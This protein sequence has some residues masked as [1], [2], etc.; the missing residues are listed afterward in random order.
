MAESYDLVVIGGGPAGYAG[1][2][3]AGQLGKKVACIEWER[4]GGTCLNWGCIPTK[5]LLRS[6]ELYQAMLHSEH[7]G[8]SCKGVDVDF[9]K[10]IERSRTVANTMGKGIEFLFK[11]NKVDYFLGRGH[12]SVPGMVEIVD[13]QDKGKVLSAKNILIAT[14]CK[15]TVIP[16]VEVDGKRVMTSREILANKKQPKSL[17]VLGAGAI[18][19]E[20]AYF[21]NAFGTEVTLVEMLPNILPVEDQEVSQTLER[22]F[23]KQGIKLHMGSKASSIEVTRKGV[24]VSLEKGGKTTDCEAECLLLAVGVKANVEGLLSKR[25]EL[26]S[27]RG[28]LTVDGRYQTSVPGIYAAGDI[29]GPPWLAHVATY[30]AVQAV[31]GM[32][33]ASEPKRVEH[34][35]G[36]TYCQP[37]VASIGITE[38]QAKEKGFNYKVGKFPF[39]ASGKAVAVNHPEGFVK[40]ITA[41]PYGEI[42]GAH[43]IG[44]DAT[45]L[46]AEFGLAMGLEATHEDIHAVI[47][48]HPTLSEAMA[49]AAA[50]V[51]GEAIHI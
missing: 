38:E 23:K 26:A 35:P 48:A 51:T 15:P 37:Q 14:G 1:A 31:N 13:G 44:A 29:I 30:E 36:C 8:F 4:A 43:I 32:F 49:E 5:T 33:G 34:F 11:K 27:D 9:E 17:V 2:I 40:V 19:V 41:E 3:R 47:H 22:S 42:I 10:V 50:S 45:E 46:I 12:I 18:G 20:F 25:V 21:F 39:S 6:A 7:F 24:K 16:G 28:F